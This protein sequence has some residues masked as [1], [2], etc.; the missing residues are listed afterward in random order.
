M[1]MKCECC[2]CKARRGLSEEE[3]DWISVDDKLPQDGVH[4]MCFSKMIEPFEETPTAWEYAIAFRKFNAWYCYGNEELIQSDEYSMKKARYSKITHWRP[5][6]VPPSPYVSQLFIRE[7]T[8]YPIRVSDWNIH[9][10]WPC[11]AGWRHLIKNAPFIG[12]DKAIKKERNQFTIDERDFFNWVS[13]NPDYVQK[14]KEMFPE[15]R[16]N[17]VDDI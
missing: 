13:K 6:P 9:F 2:Y 12:L 15:V 10:T 11:K 16:E 17:K 3:A 14:L 5:L 8:P 1:K 4:V 7:E